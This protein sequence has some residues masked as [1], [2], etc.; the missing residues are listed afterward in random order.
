MVVLPT[1]NVQASPVE[2]NAEPSASLISR[3]VCA[4]PSAAVQTTTMAVA[5]GSDVEN[6]KTVYITADGDYEAN[7]S[8]YQDWNQK[9]V[10]NWLRNILTSNNFDKKTIDKFLNEFSTKQVTGKT[11]MKF[12]QDEKL[13]DKFESTFSNENRA[14]GIWLE[15]KS[16]ISYIDIASTLTETA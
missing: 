1:S 16:A 13:M 5:F 6:G 14:F 4:K 9:Q 12:K 10:V 7:T 15:I 2:S 3:P 8:N 11:L